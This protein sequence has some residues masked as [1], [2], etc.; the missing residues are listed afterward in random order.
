[1]RRLFFILILLSSLGVASLLRAQ[2]DPEIAREA[3][4]LGED[5]PAL[6]A[7]VEREAE[8]PSSRELILEAFRGAKE[9]QSQGLPTEPYLLKANEGLA[10]G[11]SP[12]KILP[13]LQESRHRMETAAAVVDSVSPKG[14][15]L[16]PQAR[17]RA[18]LE[19]QGALLNGVS[20]R[21]LEKAIREDQSG[22]FEQKVDAASRAF[23]SRRHV[24][25]SAPSM[26]KLESYP[27]PHERV[28]KPEFQ[29]PQGK[30]WKRKGPGAMN[31]NEAWG[32]R[33]KEKGKKE[34]R[35]GF[36]GGQEHGRG[37]GSPHGQGRGK[38]D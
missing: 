18:I 28:D 2:A 27:H 7:L 29:E 4:A 16:S 10:K 9:L 31:T 25:I 8:D 11:M 3:A 35:G 33:G 23:A 15:G 38:K 36:E 26:P 22:N 17:Q 24:V 1:M 21:Q 37:H 5:S 14:A 34:S 6:K 19:M 32:N 30:G 13:A 12:K 20:P